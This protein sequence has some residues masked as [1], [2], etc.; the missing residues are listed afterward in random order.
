MNYADL[1]KFLEKNNVK[2]R[3]HTIQAAVTNQC[4]STNI[5][6]KFA[7]T[8]FKNPNA[9]HWLRREIGGIVGDD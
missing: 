9:P 6:I 4:N 1:I 2:D 7:N 3:S 5:T 8:E